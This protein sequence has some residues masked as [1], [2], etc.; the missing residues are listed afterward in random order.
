M[1]RSMDEPGETPPDLV[2]IYV[3]RLEQART[4]PPIVQTPPVRRVGRGTRA[5]RRSLRSSADHHRQ[6]PVGPSRRWWVTAALLCV[7][8]MATTLAGAALG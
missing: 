7:L 6:P 1:L 4:L 3:A 2:S 8:I 5:Y